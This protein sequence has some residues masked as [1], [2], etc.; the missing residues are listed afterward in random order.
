[1]TT[2]TYVVKGMTCGHCVSSVTQ[3]VARVAGVREVR[4]DFA[5][6]IVTV[7]GDAPFEDADVVAAVDEAGCTVVG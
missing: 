6:G 1:M 2:Q 3:E 4:V 5:T 7:E